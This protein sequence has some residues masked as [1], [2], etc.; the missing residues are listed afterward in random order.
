MTHCT[1]KPGYGRRGSGLLEFA[2]GLPALVLLVAGLS[3][4]TYSVW[5]YN[6]LAS[7]VR[8][9]ARY[10][11]ATSFDEPGHRF[12]GRVKNVVVYGQPAPG[13]AAAP[14]AP[15][16]QPGNVRVS[17]SRD[18]AG[19]PRTVTVSVSGYRL[20]ALLQ[21]IELSGRPRATAR[22]LGCWK[23]APVPGPRS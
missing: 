13:P 4:L 5:V 18:A 2:L 7:A 14:L 12:A 8:D 22:F 15:G 9:G 11:A 17:W 16:L 20:P 10:A 19:A 23:P 21:W 6:R 1:R 3:Q